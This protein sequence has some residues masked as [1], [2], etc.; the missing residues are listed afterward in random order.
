MTSGTTIMLK[1]FADNLDTRI[2]VSSELR[3]KGE[4]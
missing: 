1:L 4:T 3:V 2:N